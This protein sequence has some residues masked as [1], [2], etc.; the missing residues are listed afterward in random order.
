MVRA[1]IVKKLIFT[2]VWISLGIGLY[3]GA[4]SEHGKPRFVAP[5]GTD[6]GFCDNALRPCRSIEFAVQKANKGDKILVSGGTYKITSAEAL[7][8]LK[9][10]LVPVYGGY[11]RFDHFQTQAPNSN[12]TFLLG[13]PVEM[14]QQMRNKGFKVI[15]DG[16]SADLASELSAQMTSFRAL[17]QKQAE[18][19]CVAGSAAG[20]PCENIDLVAHVPLS[21][22]SSRPSSGND[23]WGHTDLNTGI[24]YALI[25]VNNGATVFSLE[26]PSNPV[27]VG[28]IS[29]SQSTWRDIKV[30]QY[31]DDADHRWRAYAY[32][33]VDSASD[34]VT[35][36]DLNDLP[37]SI[38]LAERNQS[39]LSAHNV[40]I[41]NVDYT[42]NAKL[43]NA[44]PLLQ[45]IGTNQYS[46]SFHSYSLTDPSTLSVK[47][48]QSTFNG[49]THDGASV[50]IDDS[51][52]DT[53]CFNGAE[54]C[55]V[56]V[57]FNEKE[58]VLWDISDPTDTQKL[59]TAGYDDVAK[60]NQYVHSGWVTEDKRF[61]LLHDEF[62][63]YRGG[64]NSTVRIFQIDDLRNPVQVGQWTGPTKA[65]DHNGFVRGN[66][67]YL[68]NYERGVTILDITD[69]AN[70]VVAGY[71]D[72]FPARNNPSFNGAWGVYPFLPSGLILASDINSGLYVLRDNT[73][74]SA[75]GSFKF[76][77]ASQNA[78]PNSSLTVQVERIGTNSSSQSASVFYEVISGSALLGEDFSL[79][80]GEL[81]W[82]GSDATSQSFTIEIADNLSALEFD[83]EFF[84]RLYNPTSGAT[85]SN[86]SYQ[87]VKIEGAPNTGNV[88]F[89]VSELQVDENGGS[90]EVVVK[91]NGGNEGTASV[92]Y[93]SVANSA[94][95]GSDYESFNGVLTWAD[96]DSSDKTISFTLID[97]DVEEPT[98]NFSINLSNSNG[99]TLGTNTS[100]LISISDDDSNTAPVVS[101]PD[102]FQ[103]NTSQS[104][105]LQGS[106][107]D[108]E[109]DD[110]IYLWTQVSGS[111][112]E[113]NNANQATAS[114]TAPQVAGNLVFNFSVIDSKGAQASA[115]LVI[116]VVAAE[117]PQPEPQQSSGGGG[118]GAAVLVILGALITRKK[119][120][121]R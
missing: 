85:I 60:A 40:Y 76:A 68:S 59:S 90:I 18:E 5:N 10:E 61:V 1:V 89:S 73:Q 23:I 51:R 13:V 44:E 91:R 54:N 52:K 29:G 79:A 72:T 58:M 26:D 2:V 93:T 81:S 25:G 80:K 78:Q 35:I 42:L 53:D 57:D 50:L 9:S 21:S 24:E 48:N 7:F 75:Q 56:F 100:M 82:V 17:D 47:A 11:N 86:P 12:Q 65:I 32:V 98:E 110:L 77:Q 62:D 69:P 88:E 33:T 97:D 115:Q 104:V 39:V 15:S 116:L 119:I 37:N 112:V 3:V 105:T 64:L 36:I 27:E 107:V 83:E 66:R 8:Y 113:L 84:I 103:V 6:S 67:Y 109:G 38:S 120:K 41:S 108:A 74:T 121:K 14:S 114:F 16:L 94:E 49:Y 34:G 43:D 46:G 4:H 55:S 28:T 96:G 45:L 87:T 95:S 20:F 71:F 117:E 30:Y 111:N 31:F 106:A 70:P 101:V 92:D 102:S 118:L 99:A 63:E 22:F 19:P